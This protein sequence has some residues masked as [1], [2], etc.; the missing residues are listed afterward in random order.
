MRV[1]KPEARAR[2]VDV[3][4]A[5]EPA[6]LALLAARGLA[7]PADAEA[8]RDGGGRLLAVAYDHVEGAPPDGL[9]RAARARLARE[10][11]ALLAAL[12]AV[13]PAEA[14]AAG[15]PELDLG[16]ELYRPLVEDCSPRLGPRGRAWIEGRFARFLADGGSRTAP[17]A[18]VHGDLAREHLLA[19]ASGRLVGAIDWADALIADPAYDLAALI[20]AGPRGFAALAADAY[21][22]RG[23]LAARDPGWRGRAAFYADALPLWQVRHGGEAERRA[24]ARRLA[25]RAAAEAR[26]ARR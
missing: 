15:V 26:A 12:H 16:E 10:T 8:V 1:L 18:L 6:L 14:R 22:R 4:H 11:G 25:A 5:R 23:G 17:R 2:G 9:P 13:P 19:D 3:G 21:R 24:G 7:V 20:A